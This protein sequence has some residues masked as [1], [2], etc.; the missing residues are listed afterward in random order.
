MISPSRLARQ[1]LGLAPAGFAHEGE[2]THCALCRGAI[3]PGEPSAPVE[4]SNAFTDW[5]SVGDTGRACGDCEATTPQPVLRNLQRVVIT[6]RGLYPIG[7]DDHRAWFLLTPPDPPFAVV[8]ST[9]SATAAFHLHWKAPVTLDRNLIVVQ[10]D[11]QALYI[12]HPILLLA[13]EACRRV[14]NGLQAAR[15]ESRRRERLNHP[16]VV[17]DRSVSEP[18]HGALHPDVALLGP[19]HADDLR[20]LRRLWPGELWALATL[21]KANPPTPTQPDLI[22]APKET[23]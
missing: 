3:A 2:A 1:A 13:L 7:T 18:A 4:F 9:R 11:D 6:E 20:L 22:T 16:F 19:E 15:P 12:R 23:A 8:V 21:A 14:A 10:L 5:A 17:L